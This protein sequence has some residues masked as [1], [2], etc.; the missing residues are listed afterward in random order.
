M[1]YRK[2]QKVCFLLVSVALISSVGTNSNVVKKF[3]VRCSLHV[4][5]E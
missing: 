5:T 1:V 2:D 3:V 4:F